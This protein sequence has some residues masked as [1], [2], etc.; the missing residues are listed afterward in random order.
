VDSINRRDAYRTYVHL[1]TEGGWLTGQ[2]RLP[3]HLT[4]KVTCEK[5]LQTLWHT[6]G[7]PV[8]VGRA[9]RI[10]PTRTRHLVHDRDRGCRFPGCTS[11]RVQCH[12]LIHWADGGPTGESLDLRW[13]TF[14]EPRT[15]AYL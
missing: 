13:V 5:I 15:P 8:N 7:A 6:H 14:H 12:H 9:Q 3:A 10:V 1:D 4:K 2:P 11:T